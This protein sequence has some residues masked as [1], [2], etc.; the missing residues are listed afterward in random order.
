MQPKPKTFQQESCAPFLRSCAAAR[1]I[2]ISEVPN[3]PISMALLKPLC[4]QRGALVAARGLYEGSHGFR[5]MALPLITSNF[6]PKLCVN[7]ASDRGAKTRIRVFSTPSIFTLSPTL[8]SHMTA[9]VTLGDATNAGELA[10]V[11]FFLL[12]GIYLLLDLS[13]ESR[14]VGP[15]PHRVREETLQCFVNGDAEAPVSKFDIW[16]DSA[17]CPATTATASSTGEVYASALLAV[18]AE[19]PE[20]TQLRGLLTAAGFHQDST[21]RIAGKRF[22]VKNCEGLAGPQPVGLK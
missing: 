6:T 5:P 1:F 22:Y 21:T 9:D 10:A 17:I 2:I 11:L 8:A 12:R 19:S 20:A 13:P 3:I 15:L 16:A 14:N 7:E 18:G 4:E